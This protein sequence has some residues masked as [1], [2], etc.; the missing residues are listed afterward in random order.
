MGVGCKFGHDAIKKLY[1]V[2]LCALSQTTYES[3]WILRR[4]HLR[5]FPLTFLCDI[6]M[7][8]FLA[9]RN[10]A[11]TVLR[12]HCARGLSQILPASSRSM[13]R[14]VKNDVLATQG[15]LKPEKKKA[16]KETP[17][18]REKT[19]AQHPKNGDIPHDLVQVA[20]ADGTTHQPQRLSHILD[21]VDL[22]THVVRLVSH[23]PPVIRIL[24]R[25]EDKMN[26]LASKAA[27]KVEGAQRVEST[28]VQLTWLT[29]GA[30][31]EH[32]LAKAREELEKG[33]A[34]VEV[35]F[36]TKPRVRYPSRPEM[37]EQMAQVAAALEESGTEWKARVIEKG[38][39]YL[40]FQS[41]T[42]KARKILPTREE[43]AAKAKEALE[44]AER[45]ALAQR[46]SQTA[47]APN[48]KD[49]WRQ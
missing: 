23:R 14:W 25:L 12:P 39:A 32:K 5:Y 40:Y 49:L 43:I 35:L 21:S 36:K 11:V 37:E 29:S 20:S 28:T 22:T 42:Q 16:V 4:N 18:P 19:T 34:R 6:F 1:F 46:R 15:T 3:E 7:S 44:L 2:W 27:K 26:Q 17:K 47:T 24:T 33:G 48:P 31:Y 10:A 45:H 13:G 38:R 9:F 30:D 8:A 41:L